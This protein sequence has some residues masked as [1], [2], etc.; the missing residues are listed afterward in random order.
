MIHKR[1]WLTPI[2][3]EEIYRIYL[4]WEEKEGQSIGRV[5]SCFP[6]H[7]QQDHPTQQTAGFFDPQEEAVLLSEVPDQA[8][9]KDRE[10]DRIST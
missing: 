1:T 7:D 6:S 5:L 8:V 10:G 4:S 3:R 9:V 2:Q